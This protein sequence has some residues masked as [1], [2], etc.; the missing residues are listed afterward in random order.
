MA[1]ALRAR[2]GGEAGYDIL[3]RRTSLLDR[4]RGLFES[5]YKLRVSG[6]TSSRHLQSSYSTAE[7]TLEAE[8]HAPSCT[9]GSGR[10]P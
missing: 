2:P 5:W 7:G 4:F 8:L 9:Q 6:I 3:F 10:H 1:L